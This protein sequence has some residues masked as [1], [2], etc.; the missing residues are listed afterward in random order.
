MF[1]SKEQNSFFSKN[2]ETNELIK[3]SSYGVLLFLIP[4]FLS[5]QLLVGVI[6]NALII[7]ASFDHSLKKVLLLCLLPSLAVVST[8]FLF[9]T[10]TSFLL[11][12]LPFI[13]I[14]NFIIACVSKKLFIEKERNYFF[15]TAMAS[16]AKSLFLFAS[17]VILF[18]F[19]L[20]P[21]L[22]LTAF[23][24]MQLVTAESG[25]IIVGLL[26]MRK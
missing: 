9:G 7:R 20:V 5:H 2:K 12:V 3:F 17:V 8:G 16:I 22:F 4:I 6:V 10:L 25:A 13:W 23:G 1:I 18:L 19:G 21:A 15:S 24:V 11:W 14:S 26:K